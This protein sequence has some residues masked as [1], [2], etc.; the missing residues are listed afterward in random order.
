M[1]AI[2]YLGLVQLPEP[3]KDGGDARVEIRVKIRRKRR[4][5]PRHK[6]EKV[7]KKAGI[8]V[9][10]KEEAKQTRSRLSKTSDKKA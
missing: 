5:G 8:Q 4:R 1:A 3:T 7:A 10:K 2:E 6:A 9:A